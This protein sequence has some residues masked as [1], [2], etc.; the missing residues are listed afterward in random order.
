[1][2]LRVLCDLWV[3]HII[4]ISTEKTNQT[5]I[6][7]SDSA[8]LESMIC[9]AK[10]P[11][12]NSLPALRQRPRKGGIAQFC[13]VPIFQLPCNGKAME[14]L[15]LIF[16]YVSC[17]YCMSNTGS[18][19]IWGAWLCL[20]W[21]CYKHAACTNR[22][23]IVRWLPRLGLEKSKT[24]PII[25]W[26]ILI[27]DD[28]MIHVWWLLIFTMLRND[29]WWF[30][31][32][33]DCFM[34]VWFSFSSKN[35]CWFIYLSSCIQGTLRTAGSCVL[36]ASEPWSEAPWAGARAPQ[37]AVLVAMARSDTRYGYDSEMT[38]CVCQAV[39]WRNTPFSFVIL[40][41]N[42]L[43]SFWRLCEH[44]ELGPFP[45]SGVRNGLGCSIQHAPSPLS[46]ETNWLKWNMPTV[47]S[48]SATWKSLGQHPQNWC[49]TD[50]HR[51][52]RA[53]ALWMVHPRTLQQGRLLKLCQWEISWGR[54]ALAASLQK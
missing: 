45:T 49:S 51:L 17:R 8:L 31:M 24:F 36:A 26:F 10:R 42:F 35:T 11:L 1:M 50:T 44:A 14:L 43:L 21:T 4:L 2:W 20:L 6:P 53:L 27:C 22:S 25:S 37:F 9:F 5:R 28:S 30:M 29:C 15:A 47:I 13:E 19:S 41:P 12:W 52:H 54:Q 48:I 23:L 7:Y 33:Y 16:H 39:M 34:I 18:W 3:Y 38:F 40:C 32:F 46:P